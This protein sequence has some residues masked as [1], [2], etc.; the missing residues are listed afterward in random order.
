[1]AHAVTVI[2]ANMQDMQAVRFVP[3]MLGALSG[4]FRN[5]LIS[6]LLAARHSDDSVR[7]NYAP[8]RWVI[9][10]TCLDR[11][12]LIKQWRHPP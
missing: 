2:G 8:I 6:I 12:R 1:M 7:M 4:P 9:Q 5:L 3:H 10:Y 11:N